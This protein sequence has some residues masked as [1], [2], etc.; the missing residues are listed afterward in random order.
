VGDCRASWSDI[1]LAYRQ[2]TLPDLQG[3]LSI[4]TFNPLKP[5][6]VQIIFKNSVRTAKKTPHFTI[7]KIN[8]LALF[9]EIIRVYTENHT[10]PINTKCRVNDCRS[11]WYK[12]LPLCFK[13]LIWCFLRTLFIFCGL[14]NDAFSSSDETALMIWQLMNNELEKMWLEAVVA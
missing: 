7:T 11:S 4:C 2:D 10:K 13:G 9:K 14:F 6:L 12:Q 3:N 8:W 5:K 1:S